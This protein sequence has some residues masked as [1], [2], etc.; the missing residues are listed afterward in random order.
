MSGTPSGSED[1]CQDD[2]IDGFRDGTGTT[3]EHVSDLPQNKSIF[4][5][6]KHSQSILAHI[7][8]MYG[9]FETSD[10]ELTVGSS[11]SK[12]TFRTH[13]IVLAQSPV[14]NTMLYGNNWQESSAKQV[15]LNEMDQY[16]F[17]FEDFLKYLYGKVLSINWQNVEALV[18]F[19]DKYAVDSLLTECL[20]FFYHH[21]KVSG[22]LL[23]ALN[24]W[25]TI[26]RI[27]SQ[28]QNLNCLT[29]IKSMLFSNIEVIMKNEKI[30]HSMDEDDLISV[31][32]SDEIVCRTEFS[33]FK[34]VEH[35]LT[36]KTAEESRL[37]QLLQ[38]TPFLRLPFMHLQEISYV[39][40]SPK[41]LFTDEDSEDFKVATSTLKS[42]LCDAYK[43]HV[44]P[45]IDRDNI[46]T[47]PK[48][49]FYLDGCSCMQYRLLNTDGLS[50][51]SKMDSFF[52]LKTSMSTADAVS[53][54]WGFCV[55]L[56]RKIN[57]R[58]QLQSSSL[59][60]QRVS[61]LSLEISQNFC[62]ATPF[63][64]GMIYIHERRGE[65]THRRPLTRFELATNR[66]K[67]D[68]MLDNINFEDVIVKNSPYQYADELGNLVFLALDIFLQ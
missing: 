11:L 38:L 56:M 54:E 51:W 53:R 1:V 8:A 29:V 18:Y 9:S 12:K 45:K 46:M 47:L 22:D 14:F 23:S 57:V 62:G 39:E 19:G 50:S 7:S 61:L 24:G 55:T 59:E 44:I 26:R 66:L 49:R 68:I 16:A 64:F 13:R 6:T 10:I 31:I 28:R 4:Q 5:S 32:S 25:K 43:F 41:R 33:L 40:N 60:K 15:Q 58:R 48:T 63:N 21:V 30:I 17:A 65:A 37:A 42:L 35:W 52:K 2:Y 34:L 3:T 27:L 20:D 36:V 67:S